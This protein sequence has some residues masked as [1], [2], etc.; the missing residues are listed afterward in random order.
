VGWVA[1][2]HAVRTDDVLVTNSS[3]QTY[4]SACVT[5]TIFN[6]CRPSRVLTE[7][8]RAIVV[9][10]EYGY[11]HPRLAEMCAVAR[12][13]GIPLIEDCAHSLDSAL[14]AGPLGSLGDFAVFSLSKVLPVPSGGVL[15]AAAPD[16]ADALP[17]GDDAGAESAYRTH[18]SALPEYTRRRRRNYAAVRSAFPDLDVLLDAGPD[19]TPWYVA[20]LTPDAPQVRR[21]SE[22]IEWGSTVQEDLLL[23]TTNPFVAPGALVSALEGALGARKDISCAS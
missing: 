6:H 21:R 12:E 10:H 22:A 19:V 4:V 23:V 15:V 16:A 1:A 9:I 7:R 14:P 2:V 18:L 3:G 20:L 5:C 17:S 13:R 8:T 11:P